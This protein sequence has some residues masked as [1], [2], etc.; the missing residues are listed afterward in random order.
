MS[1]TNSLAV[2]HQHGM[3]YVTVGSAEE[4][5][6]IARALVGEH[7]AACVNILG[8]AKSIYRWN[9]A[10]EETQ[11]I[12]LIAKT[13]LSQTEALAARVKALHS[14]DTPCIVS[15]PMDRGAPAFLAWIDDGTKSV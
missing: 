6:T 11:E 9:G 3:V 15:Y 10:V 12:V 4:A 8:P 5:E 2:T 1:Q 7:L 13:R 14:Y